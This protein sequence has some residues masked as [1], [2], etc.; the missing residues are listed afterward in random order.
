MLSNKVYR[1]NLVAF[2][3][4]E[5]HCIKKWYANGGYRMR[6]GYFLCVFLYLGGKVSGRN[7]LIL[8]RFGV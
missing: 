5:A 8:E 6:D 2:V 3:V 4:D 7:S 1:D